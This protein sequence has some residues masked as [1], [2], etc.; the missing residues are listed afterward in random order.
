MELWSLFKNKEKLQHYKQIFLEEYI[1][2]TG[3]KDI[4][5]YLPYMYKLK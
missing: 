3:D 1:S 2:L 4:V 5:N